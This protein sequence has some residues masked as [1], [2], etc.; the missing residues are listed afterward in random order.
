[1]TN[2]I[3]II[4]GLLLQRERGRRRRMLFWPE[5]WREHR[6][7]LGAVVARSLILLTR[8]SLICVYLR[9]AAL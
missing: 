2:I 7:P 8:L 9:S 1:M 5:H 6:V 3:F 4:E